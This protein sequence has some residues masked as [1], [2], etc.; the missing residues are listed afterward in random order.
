MHQT[1]TYDLREILAKLTEQEPAITALYVFGSRSYGTGSLR[2]DC[3]VIVQADPAQ[4]I[5][6]SDLLAFSTRE[7]I[8]LDLFLCTET[9]AVS[10]ANDS[11]VRAGTF[12]ALVDKLDATCLWTRE[13]GF[14]L[15][16][17]PVSGDWSFAVSAQVD[18]IASVLP[19][20]YVD[21]AAFHRKLARV[22][23]DGLPVVPYIG[24]S[25]DKAAAT[26]IDVA[27]RM[28]LRPS[29]LATR[30]S[31]KSGWTVNLSSEYD[32]QN[33]F[34]SVIKPWL[35]TLAREEVA[36]IFD[37]S[38]KKS[39][40]SLFE[41][42][43]IVE[44]K[45]IKTNDDRAGI[46]KTLDGLARFYSRNAAVKGLLFLIYVKEGVDLD[47]RQ[48]EAAYSFRTRSPWVQTVVIRVP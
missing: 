28:V 39:D 42:R 37:D 19:D 25:L 22:E 30:G 10:V 24:D 6:P 43:L 2:S 48:W 29:D 1:V 36:I 5:K 11:F 33:L 47:D 41:G 27:R 3:D 20:A 46:V 38:K 17:F 16:A 34:T 35:P 15:Y 18:F 44:M 40:F 12:D 14:E 26:I 23:Q 8:A 7:C 45:F 21:E 32:C 31:A 13:R 4:S 9:R